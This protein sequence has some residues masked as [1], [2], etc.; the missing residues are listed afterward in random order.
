MSNLPHLEMISE[1]QR[2]IHELNEKQVSF[3]YHFDEF[4][5]LTQDVANDYLRIRQ[6]KGGEIFDENFKREESSVQ[7]ALGKDEN[8]LQQIR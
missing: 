4:Q 8:L 6:A 2:D 3:V 1:L 5:R 7:M